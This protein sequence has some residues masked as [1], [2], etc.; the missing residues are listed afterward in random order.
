MAT[1][2]PKGPTLSVLYI[3]GTGTISASA[4]R[5]S[6]DIGMDVSVLNRGVNARHRSLPDGVTSI[7]ADITDPQSV[8]TV[9][10]NRHFDVVVDFLSYKAGD[11][12]TAVE[13]FGGRVGHYVQISS[14]SVYRRPVQQVPIVESSV[15]AN[16]F[17]QYAREK[18]AAE[19]VL[20]NAF[21]SDGFPVTIVRPAHTYDE[22]SPPL[23]GGWTMIERM[24]RGDEVVVHGDGTS[25]WTLTHAED[26]A[27]GLVG[28][29]GNSRT[30]GEA[31]HI[32][33]DFVY[34]WDQIYTIL[35]EALGVSPRLV[36]VPSEFFPLAAPGWIW[37]ELIEGDLSSSAVFDNSKI[38]RIV[39]E[40]CP[41]MTFERA[42]RRIIAWRGENPTIAVVDSQADAIF[43][44]LTD[45]Y[46]RAREIFISLGDS[47]A[48]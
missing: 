27:V 46:H 5:R 21:A 24:A 40:F 42:S 6:F 18:I 1:R 28:L 10:Q 22:A 19:D 33:S 8:A 25:L 14:E 37:S 23:P 7:T 16:P 2:A 36:H 31:F 17:V 44:R 48:T 3:G 9:L 35:G 11:A 13:L 43:S 47:S 39:P 34:T 20:M 12:A 41:T 15:R 29:L 32:T 45:G 38:R 30:V 26:F 4:V